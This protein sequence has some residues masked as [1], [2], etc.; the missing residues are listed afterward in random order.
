MGSII[1]LSPPSASEQCLH[2]GPRVRDQGY[3]LLCLPDSVAYCRNVGGSDVVS[4]DMGLCIL[5][6][7]GSLVGNG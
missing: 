4:E 6:E 7:V 3:I 1:S 2:L 5:E